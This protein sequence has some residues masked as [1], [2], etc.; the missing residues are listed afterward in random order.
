M[1]ALTERTLL[2]RAYGER[3][4]AR[5]LDAHLRSMKRLKAM[6]HAGHSGWEAWRQF[7]S[8]AREEGRRELTK[9]A[10]ARKVELGLWSVN[11]PGGV[12]GP[13][14]GAKGGPSGGVV[15]RVPVAWS[16]RQDQVKQLVRERE[17]LRQ[18][19]EL[20][21]AKEREREA[22]E[23][24]VVDVQEG[25]GAQEEDDDPSPEIPIV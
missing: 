7:F 5:S 4:L 23:Q 3:D 1:E 21:R 14:G 15:G 20:E 16:Q 9:K 25:E 19:R 11:G 10:Q 2:H 8:E 12:A 18:Q 13:R 6:K 22:M 17:E 24:R